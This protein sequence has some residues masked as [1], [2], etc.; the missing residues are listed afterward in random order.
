MKKHRSK[1]KEEKTQ[2]ELVPRTFKL[3]QIQGVAQNI[4]YDKPKPF[5]T[6]RSKTTIRDKN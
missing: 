1:K 5:L 4:P 6:E 3:K 2:V